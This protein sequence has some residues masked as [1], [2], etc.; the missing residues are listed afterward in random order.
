MTV[1]Y[2][3]KE[4]YCVHEGVGVKAVASV[5]KEEEDQWV[6]KWA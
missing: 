6:V 5:A 4:N 2:F 1:C 3:F